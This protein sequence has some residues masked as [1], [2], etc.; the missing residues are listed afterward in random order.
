MCWRCRWCR[1]TAW[2]RQRRRTAKR[3]MCPS[4]SSDCPSWKWKAEWIG[5]PW[6][7]W[8]WFFDLIILLYAFNTILERTL[9]LRKSVLRLGS[10]LV[11]RFRSV[12][13]VYSFVVRGL[14]W[15]FISVGETCHALAPGDT[16]AASRLWA[17]YTAGR[18]LGVPEGWFGRITDNFLRLYKVK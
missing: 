13:M 9:A 10:Y 11:V 1:M 18:L 5:S 17:M 16:G 15:A 3:A 7:L 8:R 2:W 6:W 12:F 14:L 4:T